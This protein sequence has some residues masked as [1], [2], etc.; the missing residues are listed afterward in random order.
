MVKSVAFG[1]NG[2]INLNTEIFELNICAT[3]MSE[4]EYFSNLGT[5]FKLQYLKYLYF[6]QSRVVKMLRS[7]YT[8]FRVLLHLLIL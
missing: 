6:W 1:A 5:V 3:L 8:V 7:T 2:A 4:F